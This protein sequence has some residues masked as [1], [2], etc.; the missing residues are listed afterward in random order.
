MEDQNDGRVFSS[1]MKKVLSFMRRPKLAHILVDC[2][3]L[4]SLKG[5]KKYV[6][7]NFYFVVEKFENLMILCKN[8]KSV[9]ESVKTVKSVKYNVPG[10]PDFGDLWGIMWG[11]IIGDF[12][13]PFSHSL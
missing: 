7:S 11:L 13:S 1:L 10:Q 3:I 12:R 6:L 2:N 4:P 9:K 8:Q 5:L